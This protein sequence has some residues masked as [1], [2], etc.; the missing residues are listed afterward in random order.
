[1]GQVADPLCL[2]LASSGPACALPDELSGWS[3]EIVAEPGQFGGRLLALRPMLAVVCAPPADA[4][5]LAWVI[6]ERVRRPE[7]RVVFVDPPARVPERLEALAA[8]FDDAFA[9]SISPR[10]LDGRLDL[11]AGRARALR[12]TLA[13]VAVAPSYQLDLLAHELLRDGQR[14]P[15]RP[16]EFALLSELAREPGVVRGRRELLDRVW[17]VDTVVDPRTLDVHIR[18]LRLKIE[19]T[20]ERPAHLITVRGVGYR[21]DTLPL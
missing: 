18:R 20:P 10:E 7:L 21:L 13:R 19:P 6:A 16:K 8:G 14:I 1:M 15:L 4:A 3:V 5:D 9:G 11:L 17:G 12:P 2:V